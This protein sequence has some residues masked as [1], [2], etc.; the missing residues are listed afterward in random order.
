MSN[1]PNMEYLGIRLEA[2]QLDA[3]KAFAARDQRT[4]SAVVRMAVVAFL[5]K[6]SEAAN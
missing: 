2:D 3:V 5:A 4:I 6:T 1:K